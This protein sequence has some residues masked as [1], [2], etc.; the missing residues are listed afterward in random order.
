DKAWMVRRFIRSV[1]K[2]RLSSD[3]R[4]Y[5]YLGDSLNDAP[6]FAAFAL[7]VGVANVRAVLELLAPRPRFVTPAPPGAGFE[8]L[9]RAVLQARQV[10]Q[11]RQTQQARRAR[12]VLR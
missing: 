6:L 11:A 10:R 7:S 8:E 12:K 2:R 1:W 3:D 9:G 5:V 4:R